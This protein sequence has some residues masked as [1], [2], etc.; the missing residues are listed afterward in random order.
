MK[1]LVSLFAIALFASV[2]V[3]QTI[4]SKTS[5]GNW[6]DAS[7]WV[8]GVVPTQN[9][10]VVIAGTVS[11]TSSNSACKNLTINSGTT[12][13]NGGSLGWVNLHIY[14]ATTN[15]GTIRNNPA[16]YSFNVECRGDLYNDG[17]WA[18]GGT[19]IP[20][21]QLQHI[22]SAP[23]S[24]FANH[25]YMRDVSGYTDTTGKLIATSN[26]IFNAQF[27]LQ[28]LVIDLGG[29]TLTL[30]SDANPS[31][32][33]VQNASHIYFEDSSFLYNVTIAGTTT[34]LHG[35][36]RIDA[37]VYFTANIINNDV[38]QHTGGLS[39][40]TPVFYGSLTNNGTIRNNP[41]GGWQI[42]LDLRSDIRNNG[43]WKPGTTYIAMKQHQL[44]SQAA[45]KVFENRVQLS[46][47]S[48]Y[49][50]TNGSVKAASPLTFSGEVNMKWLVF[51]MDSFPLTMVNDAHLS[52]GTITHVPDIY[53]RDSSYFYSTIIASPVMLH[54]ISRFADAGVLF[55]S[56]VI[57]LDT[58]QHYG[59]LGWV[60]TTILGNF[61]NNGVV[62]NN[63]IGNGGLDIRA[64]KNIVNNGYWKAGTVILDGEGRRTI[65]MRNA[66]SGMRVEG[67]KVIFVG[68][69]Y[70]PTLAMSSGA[71]CYVASEATLTVLD[72]TTDYGWSGV[73]NLGRVVIPRKPVSGTANYS[74]YAGSYTLA[75]ATNIPDSII[76]TSYGQQT[77]KS[78]GN[79]VS[80]WFHAAIK[81]GTEVTCN[82]LRFYYADDALNGNTED[83]LWLYHSTDNGLHWTAIDA[84]NFYQRNK[85]YN[86][87]EFKN[88]PLG[89]DYVLSSVSTPI[90][91]RPNV[92]VTVVGN[93][94]LRVLAPN[95]QVINVYNNS[96]APSGDVILTLEVNEGLRFLKTEDNIDGFKRTYGVDD[97]LSDSTDQY[98]TFIVSSLAAHEER[99][100]TVYATSKT[101]STIVSKNKQPQFFWFIGV[102]A[103]YVAGAYISDYVTDKMV[104]GCFDAWAPQG[105]ATAEQKQLA[106]EQVSS[107]GKKLAKD[108]SLSTGKQLAEDG[109]KKI[110]EHNILGK[111]IWPAKLGYNILSCF[112]NTIK[113][114]QCYQGQTM[115]R[116]V[117]THVECNGSQKQ[118]RVIT[119]RDPNHKSGPQGYGTQGYIASAQRM[120]YLIECENAA[121]AAAPAYKIVIIDTLAPEFDENTVIFGDMSHQ[122]T[123]SRTGNILRW[124][125][126][127]IDLPP[128]KVPTEG[129]SWVTY[130]V[131]PKAGTLAGTVFGNSAAIYFDANA[132]IITNRYVN[133]LDNIAPVSMMAALPSKTS[134]SVVT[135]K[136]TST[137]AGGSGY[138]SAELFMAK[139][140]GEYTAVCTQNTDSV[141]VA[142]DLEHSYSFFVLSKDNVG[143][144]EMERPV[145]VS[146]RVTSGVA[147]L[148]LRNFWLRDI[149]PNPVSGTMNIEYSLTKNGFTAVEMIDELGRVIASV[150]GEVQSEG[151]YH[152]R[153][154][155][156]SLQSGTYYLRL[157]QGG[158]VQ[159]KKVVVAK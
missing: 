14:G 40:V 81:P 101:P 39:W 110:L 87:V 10:D 18:P 22:S 105:G 123:T 139:D 137:D 60:T 83:S 57:N 144:L 107:A 118:V 50:D 25:F 109:A 42:A 13:Q 2:S 76:I 52:W 102:A 158:L 84:N 6:E 82:Y 79:A 88:I 19:F 17:T 128:N 147:P 4:T 63:P 112:E 154:D 90:P 120:E 68:D 148:D 130:S 37:A 104:Q 20:K 31:W 23:G 80:G 89:G 150:V 21:K 72:G 44:I 33:T 115:I 67:K 126:T 12:I 99:D 98:A 134:D 75:D 141:Q 41:I 113:G 131:L 152:Y 36:A 11:V 35:I 65:D 85:G 124:E 121:D 122:Y 159:T 26:L 45:G 129:E 92:R 114:L 145:P 55:K 58:M 93:P 95:R 74:F 103:V 125:I 61:V 16:G 86:F 106:A 27:D 51:D 28:W 7:T 66:I 9:N 38:M 56:D 142:V 146:I 108:V 140:D 43:I 117:F 119:S 34:E 49:T 96:D 54:G 5:G 97:F 47:A 155:G 157:T 78:F 64:S 156:S 32:G 132:P 73:S 143:N 91:S 153:F 30:R 94:D 71:L 111:L 46:D 48:G 53:S 29:N 3:S 135:I 149:Y 136:W 59:G 15:H 24:V 100:F 133:T 77:P 138:E 127:G 69:N 70:V 116:D 1:Y 8:G 62:R 151:I